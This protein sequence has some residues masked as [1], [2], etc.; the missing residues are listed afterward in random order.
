MQSDRPSRDTVHLL[1]R[2]RDGER[3]ALNE[4]FSRYYE[5]VLA[6]VCL[7][8]GP[9]LRAK[10]EAQDVVQE[11]FMN[12][13]QGL[14]NFVYRSEGDFFHWL[15]KMVENRIRDQADYFAAQKRDMG[16]EVPLWP[17]RPSAESLYGP[18]RE[19]AT[20]TSPATRAAQAESAR[21]LQAAIDALPSLQREALILVRYEGLSL[22][23]AGAHLDRSGDA[24]RM[25]VARAIVSLGKNLGVTS[26][27]G[28]SGG[29]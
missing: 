9:K 14:G 23:E 11:V 24:L 29:P 16:R 26:D 18:L 15:C 5:R 13:L 27:K 17:R 21:R 25:L 28:T 7:R 10:V 4:L 22:A 3:A 8:L 2:F 1:A 6:V 12:S 20:T 19:L